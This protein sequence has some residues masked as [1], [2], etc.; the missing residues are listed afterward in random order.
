MARRSRDGRGL[1]YIYETSSVTCGDTFLKGEGWIGRCNTVGAD[2]ISACL[3]SATTSSVCVADTFPSRGR[4]VR[5]VR[6][7]RGGYHPPVFY[8]LRRCGTSWISLRLGPLA[9][10]TVY[11][12]VIHCRSCRFATPSPTDSIPPCALPPTCHGRRGRGCA[13]PCVRCGIKKE[14]Y[15]FRIGPMKNPAMLR[16]LYAAGLA[17]TCR[18]FRASSRSSPSSITLA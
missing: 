6:D 2:S 15:P 9:V 12:T 16:R 11:R 4:L 14:P 7:C 5:L 1:R 3:R 10:L 13:T 18:R 8:R 17:G